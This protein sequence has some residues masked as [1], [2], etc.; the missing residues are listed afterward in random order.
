MRRAS[1]LHTVCMFVILD[2]FI[3]IFIFPLFFMTGSQNRAQG[4]CKKISSKIEPI[5]EIQHSFRGYRYNACSTVFIV[6]V[7]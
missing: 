6:Y 1:K 4:Q 2:L 7:S 3:C 5:F